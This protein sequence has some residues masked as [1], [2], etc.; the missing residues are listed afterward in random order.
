MRDPGDI[1]RW[2]ASEAY[3][4]FLTTDCYIQLQSFRYKEYLG[5]I[6]AIGNAVKG[7]KLTD[8]VKVN[9]QL[10]TTK[11]D[12]IDN[13]YQVEMSECCKRLLNLLQRLQGKIEEF[14][15]QEIQTR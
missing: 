14:P 6:I 9:L 10:L 15:P 1:V 3:Q 8:E 7:R 5:F 12:R 2:E 13:F 4:V 11:Q